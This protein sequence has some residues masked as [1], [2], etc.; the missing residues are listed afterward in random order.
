MLLYVC[1]IYACDM[2]IIYCI[3]MKRE[4]RGREKEKE[5]EGKRERSKW[6]KM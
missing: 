1:V 4:R 2:Y 5:K 3:Y 6:D